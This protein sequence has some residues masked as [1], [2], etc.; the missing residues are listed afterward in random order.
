MKLSTLFKYGFIFLLF[1][2]IM[3]ACFASATEI[4]EKELIEINTIEDL[5]LISKNPTGNYILMNDL[6]FG[7]VNWKEFNLLSDKK[8]E[9]DFEGVFDG[10]NKTF[11]IILL[12]PT[13]VMSAFLQ[14]SARTAR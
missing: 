9:S 13:K 1:F 12:S 8:N 5:A 2:G 6:D 11:E 10:N 4:A 14:L 3:H 7:N